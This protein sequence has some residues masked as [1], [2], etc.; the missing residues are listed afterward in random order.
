[1]TPRPKFQFEKLLLLYRQLL[2]HRKEKSLPQNKS[3]LKSATDKT[4]GSSSNGVCLQ[5]VACGKSHTK[6][7]TSSLLSNNLN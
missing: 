3:F 4:T 2:H 7:K 1:M 6:H 5:N